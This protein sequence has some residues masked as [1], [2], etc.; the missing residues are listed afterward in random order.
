MVAESEEGTRKTIT[1]QVADVNKGL[2][3][4]RKIVAAGNRVV[5][6]SD[7]YI[8]DKQTG[9]RMWLTEAQGMYML[10]MWVKNGP[11]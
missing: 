5:F 1:A 3:S 11:F 8:E 7:S 9:E 6:D 2:L 4:V 10:K